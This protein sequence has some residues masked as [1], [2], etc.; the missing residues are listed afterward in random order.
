M[1][2]FTGFQ[3]EGQIA[4]DETH[5]ARWLRGAYHEITERKVL[6][7][8][9]LA[10]NET[11]EARVAEVR[12][13][14]RT[15]EILNRTCVAVAGELDLERLVQAVT[16]AGVELSQA[17]FGAF[18]YNVIRED[19]ETY[20]LCAF[21]GAPHEAF[22]SFPMP[23]NTAVFE[24]TFRGHGAVRSHDILADP[25]YGQNPPYYGMP[26]DHLPMR[27]YLA[28]PVVSRSGEVLGGLFF[29]HSQPGV[30]T[31]RAE[32]IATG[33]AAQAAV[34]I[35]NARLYQISQR[36]IAARRQAEQELQAAERN[37]RRAR[38]SARSA[39]CG[40]HNKIGGN[41]APFPPAGRSRY[42]LRDFH[43][44]SGG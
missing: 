24:A 43:A 30:F 40:K 18:F 21:S 38:R 5:R 8:R 39:A 32:R 3:D 23:R 42:R 19:G 37:A 27:S 6:E 17:Q 22:A 25:R 2:A 44:R 20:T 10:L 13:E 15:L 31:E 16:D 1:A 11:L 12:D 33:L 35:D 41:R 28:V 4:W 9:L 34:A 14:A 7:A 26:K 36:E 29:G